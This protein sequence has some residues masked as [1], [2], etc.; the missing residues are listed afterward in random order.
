[1]K[2]FERYVFGKASDEDI[3]EL[4]DWLKDNPEFSCWMEQQ[5]E[6]S[7]S[8]IDALSQYKM[9][10][11][12]RKKTGLHSESYIKRKW[13]K[14]AAVVM[15]PIFVAL[16]LIFYM[17]NKS[18]CDKSPYI[19]AVEKGQKASAV[20]PDGTKVWLN[21]QSEL[22]CAMDFN[23][24]RREV[25][26]QGE[27]YFEVAHDKSKPFRVKCGDL[28]VEALGTA[29]VVRNYK[30]D[31]V[32]SSV[33]V[34][35]RIRVATLGGEVMLMPNERVEYDKNTHEKR[36]EHITNASDFADWRHNEFRFEDQSFKEIAKD[37][38]R[39]YNIKLVFGSKDIENMRFTGTVSN[40]SL[41]SLLNVF[42]LT[43][44]LTFRIEKGEVI[45]Q[46]K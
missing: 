25:E 29:F 5:I 11:N 32:I 36:V 27:A 3:V 30:E 6:N 19:I 17:P 40:S 20:L 44:S 37:I 43:S 10:C 22:T 1:M 23:V 14:M 34:N 24:E 21:S 42:A 26:L 35:G 4:K 41:E 18:I 28:S 45:L 15:L 7:S 9:F 39:A 46:K 16:G 8:N 33:L 38:E 31:G 12:I 2:L 13:W